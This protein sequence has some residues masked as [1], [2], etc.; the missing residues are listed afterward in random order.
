MKAIERIMAIRQ[1]TGKSLDEAKEQYLREKGVDPDEHYKNI[2][3][4]LK[5]TLKDTKER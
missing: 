5:A 3:E 2:T 4:S 1:E